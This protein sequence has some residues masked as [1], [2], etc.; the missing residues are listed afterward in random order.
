MDG[1]TLLNSETE[2]MSHKSVLKI[3]VTNLIFPGQK[4]GGLLFSRAIEQSQINVIQ[5]LTF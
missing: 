1:R 2:P 5:T 3:T 4:S